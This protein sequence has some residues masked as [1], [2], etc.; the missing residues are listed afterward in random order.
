MTGRRE[1]LKASGLAVAGAVLAPRTLVAG[2]GPHIPYRMFWSW[3][4]S[5]NWCENVPG[6]QNF[7]ISSPYTKRTAERWFEKDY[8]RV[9]DWCAAHDMQAVGITGLVRDVHGGIDAAR[10]LCGYAREKGVRV[11]VIGGLYAY[12]GAYYEGNSPW[13]LD[14][15]FERNPDAIARDKDGKPYYANFRSHGGAKVE[16]QG[17]P[18]N[19]KLRDYVLESYDWLFRTIPELGGIQMEAGDNGVCQCPACKARRGA[20]AASEYM[21]LEDMAGI[22]PRMVD[23]VRARAKD[24]LIIC[25]TYHHFLDPACGIFYEKEPGADAKALFDMP[26]DVFWQWKCD[27]VLDAGEWTEGAPLPEPLKGFNHVMRSHAGTQWWRG[28]GAF[29]V[30]KIR[31]QCR[32]SALS[33]LNGVSM[34]GEVSPYHA[35]AE[36]NYLALQYFADAPL[37]PLADFVSDVMAPRLGGENPAARWLEWAR[38]ENQPEK[39]AAATDEIAKLVG[40]VKDKEARRRWLYL[41]ARLESFRWEWERNGHVL[42]NYSFRARPENGARANPSKPDHME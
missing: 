33:G 21:S 31:L 39:I 30:E 25:E 12:G 16:A 36:F 8:R 4:H 26:K 42:P 6:A 22:Y 3:D 11:Y 23:T 29:D 14:K 28:R 13:S 27:R 38:L 5:T 32:L 40:G 18:S 24:A 20:K 19:A 35:N 9:I 2:R 37:A 7:G 10:R 1:F 41:A 17:C 34:F 15:F